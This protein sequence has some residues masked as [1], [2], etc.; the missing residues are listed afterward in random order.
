[1]LAS[2]ARWRAW[3]PAYPTRLRPSACSSR[4]SASLGSSRLSLAMYNYG[5]YE[6]TDEKN[7]KRADILARATERLEHVLL[8][9][10]CARVIVVAHSLG[11]AIAADALLQLGRHNRARNP[12]NPIAGPVALEKIVCLVTMGSP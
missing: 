3:R 1:M 9:H 11:T 12:E 2:A 5:T 7:K 4:R 8:D 6:E 10:R